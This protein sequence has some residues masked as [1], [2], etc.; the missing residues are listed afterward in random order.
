MKKEL[1]ISAFCL[2]TALPAA[3]EEVTCRDFPDGD[4]VQMEIIESHI[5]GDVHNALYFDPNNHNLA[6]MMCGSSLFWVA[7][8]GLTREAYK[9]DNGPDYFSEGLARTVNE[10]GQVGFVDSD[11]EIAIAPQFDAAHAFM[12][13]QAIV[14]RVING[15][16]HVATIDPAGG[17]IT[18]FEAVGEKDN[19]FRLAPIN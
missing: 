13:G 9:Y 3:A 16:T 11:L 19:P 8:S 17:Q 5:T 10:E 2:C 14:G 1:L 12:N 7:E 4:P 6:V 15:Q 18:E